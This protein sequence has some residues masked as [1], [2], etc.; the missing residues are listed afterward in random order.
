[1]FHTGG[2]KVDTG[3]FDA[4]MAQYVRQLRHIPA[5]PVEGPGE[6][7]PQIVGEHLGFLHPR[8]GADGL[9]L[10]P[11]LPPAQT[12]SASGEEYLPGGDL[13]FSGIF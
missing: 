9:H 11:Y 12:P 4:G 3:G 8:T 13:L 7:M 5:G 6:E 2:N 1:M 10:R